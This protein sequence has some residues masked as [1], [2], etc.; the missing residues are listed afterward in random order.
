[1]KTIIGT[2]LLVS[3]SALAI[4]LPSQQSKNVINMALAFL[5]QM[6]SV[7]SIVTK[8]NGVAITYADEKNE[9]KVQLV[10]MKYDKHG[11][12]R[13]EENTLPPTTECSSPSITATKRE[14]F[15]IDALTSEQTR[16]FVTRYGAVVDFTSKV[17]VEQ[18]DDLDVLTLEGERLKELGGDIPCGHATLKV[19]R[20]FK[21]K[22]NGWGREHVYKA[23]WTADGCAKR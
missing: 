15:I 13:V 5:P 10:P 21:A 22:E 2:I 3:A 20:T 6:A 19:F 1:M 7:K 18:S 16:E 14:A 17:Q 11:I 8:N 9:C 4:S 12:P 23:L